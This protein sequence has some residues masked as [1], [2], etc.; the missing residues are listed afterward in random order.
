MI[1]SAIA[2]RISRLLVRKKTSLVVEFI[3]KG[4]I[5]EAVQWEQY[6]PFIWRFNVNG[7]ELVDAY[8]EQSRKA[9]WSVYVDDKRVYEGNYIDMMARYPYLYEYIEYM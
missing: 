3:E 6:R 1:L 2:K 9:V 5:Y 7:S 4:Y 8:N